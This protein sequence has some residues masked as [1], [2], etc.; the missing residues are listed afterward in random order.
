VG[1]VA[2]GV[3]LDGKWPPFFKAD[4]AGA[5]L[6]EAIEQECRTLGH[7]WRR[8]L[9]TPVVT[10]QAFLLQVLHGNLACAGVNPKR[11]RDL[12][13]WP[14]AFLP[15]PLTPAG[16]PAVPKAANGSGRLEINCTSPLD[17]VGPAR[18]DVRSPRFRGASTE[19]FSGGSEATS[20]SAANVE[21]GLGGTLLST[22]TIE[23]A[24][25]SARSSSAGVKRLPARLSGELCSS[26]SSIRRR[27][28]CLRRAG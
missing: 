1:L 24:A 12:S 2:G 4:V 7:A 18:R 17:E 28:V 11:C 26:H 19:M 14:P 10:V 6:P 22:G 9:L 5:L 3:G 16:M 27:V 8:R 15:V 13:R 21:S 20:S 25:N 23:S